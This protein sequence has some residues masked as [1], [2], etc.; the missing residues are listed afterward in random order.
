MVTQ[1]GAFVHIKCIISSGVARIRFRGV[2][3]GSPGDLGEWNPT[4]QKR[5]LRVL[6]RYFFFKF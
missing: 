4:G 5:G 2:G 6:P 3:G 1:S